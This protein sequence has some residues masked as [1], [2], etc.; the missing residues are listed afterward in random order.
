MRRP[1]WTASRDGPSRSPSAAAV[2]SMSGT[3]N[4]MPQSRAGPFGWAASFVSSGACTT[5]R[6]TSP[7]R[8]NAWRSEPPGVG[9]SRSRR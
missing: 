8:K 5:S 4:E 6:I 3:R 2:T 1:G 9:P 7:I